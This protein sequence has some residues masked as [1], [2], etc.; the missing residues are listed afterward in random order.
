[1]QSGVW[2]Y[3]AW[4]ADLAP[5]H[6]VSRGEGNTG[7]YFSP[8]RLSE[9]AGVDGFWLKHEGENP[10]GSFKDRGMCV[11]ISVA[12][13]RGFLGVAC[14]STGNTSASMASYA[15]YCGMKAF[16]FLPK[17]KI[18][19][20]KLAQALAYGA[21]T[22]S[23]DGNFDEALMLCESLA[24]R[25]GIALLNSIN[26]FRLEGQKTIIFEILENLN[27]EVPD[28]IVV[29]G[30]NLGNVSAFG[31]A[32]MELRNWGVID[33]LPRLAVVQ[34]AKASPFVDYFNS[35]FLRFEACTVPE[36]VA[37]AI[38]IGNPVSVKRA[39]TSIENSNGCVVAVTDE[40][41]LEA[42]AMVDRVG[43]GAEPASCAS[44]AGLK[45]LVKSQMIKKDAKVVTV[46]TGNL[47]KDTETVISQCFSP[48][49][50]AYNPV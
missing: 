18:A 36:T 46:L 34:A 22:V 5:V 17:G 39:K 28:W 10:T 43:I 3:A 4:H 26:P 31:K 16:V 6:R 15:A 2:R 14:A 20:G 32:L 27:W 42:K 9:F 24:P 50:T 35:G 41:I 33:R 25:L 8:R 38:R 13:A 48:S 30:G 29:P 37:T 1:M 21:N 44:V 7:M 12:K 47:M 40:E 49:S 19:M 45:K 11:A 23:I